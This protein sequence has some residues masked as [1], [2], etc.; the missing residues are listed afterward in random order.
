MNTP[1]PMGA[2]IVLGIYNLA[3]AVMVVVGL[4]YLISGLCYGM[5]QLTIHA[6]QRLP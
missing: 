1:L 5:G 6:M 2:A 3:A 4:V